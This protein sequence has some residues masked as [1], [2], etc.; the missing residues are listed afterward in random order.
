V[1]VD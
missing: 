1:P